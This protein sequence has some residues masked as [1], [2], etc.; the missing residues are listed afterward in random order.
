VQTCCQ[1]AYPTG[2]QDYITIIQNCVCG[3]SGPCRT[4]CANEYCVDG[5]VTTT[6]DACDTC[7][8]TNLAAGAKCDAETATGTINKQCTA[9]TACNDYL[10]CANGCP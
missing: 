1:G 5:T 2:I 3:T 7:L 10:V 9:A 6:G 4:K 8:N